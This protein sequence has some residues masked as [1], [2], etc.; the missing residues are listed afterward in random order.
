MIIN[1]ICAFIDNSFKKVSFDFQNFKQ[2]IKMS[3]IIIFIK[4]T[5]FLFQNW[6]ANLKTNK[7]VVTSRPADSITIH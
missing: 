3:C 7:R 6:Q 4:N 1:A 5:R 2:T